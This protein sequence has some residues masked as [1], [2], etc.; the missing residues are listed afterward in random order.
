MMNIKLPWL[1]VRRSEWDDRSAQRTK[2]I[3]S[4]IEKVAADLKENE[5]QAQQDN[6]IDSALIAFNSF[7]SFVFL[8]IVVYLVIR[9]KLYT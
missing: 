8:A 3:M 9:L 2:A 7:A 5:I 4:S 1:I 6:S